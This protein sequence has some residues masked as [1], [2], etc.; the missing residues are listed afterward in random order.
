MD[1]I[2][3]GARDVN[4]IESLAQLWD[5]DKAKIEGAFTKLGFSGDITA[6]QAAKVHQQISGGLVTKSPKKAPA[7]QLE[8]GNTSVLTQGAT[9]T[10]TAPEAPTTVTP[11]TV[12]MPVFD[13]LGQQLD[14]QDV[15]LN[16][17]AADLI[18]MKM[19]QM[20]GNLQTTVINTMA[21]YAEMPDFFDLGAMFNQA[22]V[23]EGS[24]NTPTIDQ[25]Q[26][27]IDV[28]AEVS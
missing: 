12:A 7:K 3:L 5:A 22:P 23:L 19:Q 6:E 1:N 28:Q 14:A 13:T 10:L 15:A 21:E 9:A 26:E 11:Q 20:K 4:N 2:T 8:G 27:A 17:K 16:A 24:T 18:R 25:V